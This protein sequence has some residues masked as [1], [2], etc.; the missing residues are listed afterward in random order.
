MK[1]DLL[2]RIQA[3]LRQHKWREIN[4]IAERCGCSPQNLYRLRRGEARTMGA[5]LAL[6]LA[7]ELQVDLVDNSRTIRAI[8]VPDKKKNKRSSS[9][10]Q[11]VGERDVKISPGELDLILSHRMGRSRLAHVQRAAAELRIAFETAT[12]PEDRATLAG[13]LNL[14]EAQLYR[15]EG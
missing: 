14:L 11:S 4:R 6:R 15:M 12:K 9:E 13:L 3:A 8:V 2:P 5:D 1:P 10:E 7:V